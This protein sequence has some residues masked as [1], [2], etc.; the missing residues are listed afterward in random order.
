MGSQSRAAGSA[1]FIT[2]RAIAYK[3]RDNVNEL[4]SRNHQICKFPRFSFSRP[5]R[6]TGLFAVTQLT[7]KIQSSLSSRHGLVL[8]RSPTLVTNVWLSR[9]VWL[10]GLRSGR[11]SPLIRV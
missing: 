11:I 2:A 3:I 8:W 9:V 6:A 5:V 7:E 1:W 4:S 10:M